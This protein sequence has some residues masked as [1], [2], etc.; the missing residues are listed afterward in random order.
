MAKEVA[1]MVAKDIQEETVKKEEQLFRKKFPLKKVK[2][3]KEAE[4]ESE[5]V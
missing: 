3:H 5:S 4:I 2:V 1:E